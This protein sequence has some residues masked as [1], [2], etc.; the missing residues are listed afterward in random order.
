MRHLPRGI[1]YRKKLG[2]PLPL[3]DYMTPLVQP[4]LFQDGYCVEQLQLNNRGLN[5][6]VSRWTDNV[7]GMFSL[8]ALEIWGRLN[9]R[10]ETVVAVQEH[11]MS[12]GI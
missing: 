12:L 9:M 10:G 8:L 1:V 3:Q 4:K 6:L 2:F 11:L 5:Q 7:D